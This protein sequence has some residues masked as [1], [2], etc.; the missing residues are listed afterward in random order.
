[1]A[2]L[3]TVLWALALAAVGGIVASMLVM[4]A[5][6]AV[7]R[8]GRSADRDKQE[9]YKTRQAHDREPLKGVRG[10]PR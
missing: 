5:L 1:M 6:G 3:T 7:A 4:G 8:L 2:Q 9:A 10:K